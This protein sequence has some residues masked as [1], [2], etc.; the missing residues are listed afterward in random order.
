MI[1]EYFSL[2]LLCIHKSKDIR[3]NARIGFVDF[4]IV[5]SIVKKMVDIIVLNRERIGQ[6]RIR[7]GVYGKKEASIICIEARIEKKTIT[8]R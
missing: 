2:I 4:L 5:L 8:L 3:S 7:C 6:R 1:A